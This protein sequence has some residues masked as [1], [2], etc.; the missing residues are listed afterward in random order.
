MILH[1]VYHITHFLYSFNSCWNIGCSRRL[2]IINSAAKN[3]FMKVPLLYVEFSYVT[4]KIRAGLYDSFTFSSL[5]N[6]YTYYFHS[7]CIN[8]HLWLGWDGISLWFWFAF[9]LWL[10][11]LNISLWNCYPFVFLHMRPECSIYLPIYY[12]IFLLV[13]NFIISF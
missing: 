4:K 3:S 2:T 5:G 8:V 6:L 1:C 10:R 9:L 12:W 7:G 11:M 13:F